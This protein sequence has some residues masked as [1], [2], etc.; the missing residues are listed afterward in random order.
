MDEVMSFM[1]PRLVKEV[2]A[3]VSTD[4][5]IDFL[6]ALHEYR[7]V[8]DAVP[9]PESEVD[10]AQGRKDIQR[11]NVI[12]NGVQFVGEEKMEHFINALQAVALSA[13]MT[14][15]QATQI[16][17]RILC[18]T[19][20]TSSGA[21]SYFLMKELFERPSLLLKPR[22]E[23]IPPVRIEMRGSGS[24]VRCKVNTTNLF[25]LYR[26][27]DIEECTKQ[28]YT[29]YPDAWVLLDT[30]V[31]ETLTF[32]SSTKLRNVTGKRT[33]SIRSPEP[34]PLVADEVME[35]F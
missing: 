2:Q 31:T 22:V 8:L 15:D 17:E 19:S 20:R 35:L 7:D 27:E 12:L 21:D 16:T 34:A 33:L 25:G 11:E 5:K 13:N 23:Q 4:K 24:S 29:E 1:P 28:K 6:D 18:S 3:L 26:M 30:V 14:K 9:L 10:A 32:G